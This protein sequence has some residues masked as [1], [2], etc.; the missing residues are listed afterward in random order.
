MPS[1]CDRVRVASTKVGQVVRIGTLTGVVGRLLHIRWSTI[2]PGPGPV[3]VVGKVK[4]SSSKK[5]PAKSTKAPAKKAV[6]PAKTVR[7][8]TKEVSGPAKK[9]AK[10][11]A[12]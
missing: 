2:S 12:R 6:A 7:A 10:N 3:A 1:V 4:A 5:A 9:T 11:P 8:S